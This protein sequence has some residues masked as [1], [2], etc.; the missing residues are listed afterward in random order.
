MSRSRLTLASTLA[1]AIQA[2]A[3]SPPITGNDGIGSPGTRNPSESTYPGRTD[4]PATARRMP[5]ILAAC[6]P[7]RSTSAAGINTT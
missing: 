5:S 2:A 1:A 4:N 7:W 3:A 6:T